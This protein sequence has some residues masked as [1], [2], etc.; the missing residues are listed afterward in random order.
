MINETNAFGSGQLYETTDLAGKVYSVCTACMSILSEHWSW[1]E[2][3]NKNNPDIEITLHPGHADHLIVLSCQVTELAILNDLRMLEKLMRDYPGEE[4][5]IGGC[6]ARRFDIEMPDGVRRVG[7]LRHDYQDLGFAEVPLEWA[8]PFW[9]KDYSPIAGEL[10]DGHL[11]RN[12]YPLRIS[13][14]CKRNCTYCSI[15]HTRGEGYDLDPEKQIEEFLSHEDV[16]LIADS[17]SASLIKAW[18]D[19]AMD[20]GKPISIRNVE[21]SVAIQCLPSFEML[22]LVGLLR[23]LHVPVQSDNQATLE[24]MKR[25]YSPV[26]RLLADDG[27][28]VLKR[29]GVILATNVIVDYKDFPDPDMDYL[30]T[31]FDYISWNPY[32]DGKWDRKRAEERD[33]ELFGRR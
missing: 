3:V 13:V 23:I 18:C 4:Y 32:W 22:S 6:L 5:Y 29:N 33:L 28:P 12:M 27:L 17:P 8:T 15:K 9:V 31:I 16:L 11:F 25:G 24:C 1:M 21:P 7:S 14:G 30:N 10:A 2:W 26:K 19:L 20:Y